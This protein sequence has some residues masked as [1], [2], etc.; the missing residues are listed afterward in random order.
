M[1]C[2]R[3]EIS[4]ELYTRAMAGL[5]A[6]IASHNEAQWADDIEAQYETFIQIE[7][8]ARL[9]GVMFDEEKE[10]VLAAGFAEFARYAAHSGVELH[11]SLPI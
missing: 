8:C 9:I 3:D 7:A 10:A 11:E 4:Q 1:K 6:F 2:D 5:L